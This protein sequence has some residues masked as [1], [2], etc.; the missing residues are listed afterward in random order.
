M[1]QD[2]S[3]PQEPPSD[4]S[5]P[6]SALQGPHPEA[7]IGAEPSVMD[8]VRSVLDKAFPATKRRVDDSMVSGVPVVG[9]I[10]PEDT[11]IGAQ[12]VRAAAGKGL[13]VTGRI[14]AAAKEAEPIVKYEAVKTG[15]RWAG[16]P[17]GPAAIIAGAAVGYRGKKAA[18]AAQEVAPAAAAEMPAGFDRYA[19]NVSGVPESASA[20][21][22]PAG[23]RPPVVTPAESRPNALPDQRALN[24]AAL[25]RR[26]AEYSAGQMSK[27][28]AEGAAAAGAKPKLTAPESKVYLELREKDLTDA[29]ARDLIQASRGLGELSGTMTDAQVAA[30]IRARVGNRSPKR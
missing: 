14:L 7:R 3:T 28:T 17:E 2:W 11:L 10:N 29:E 24:E 19:P 22:V 21:S 13:G 26:R 25:A 12:I 1:P 18:T 30:E 5:A 4:W 23:G 20:G 16:V 27:M 6:Q 15:L 8:R 9:S